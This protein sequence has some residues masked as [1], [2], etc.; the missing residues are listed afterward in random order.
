MTILYSPSHILYSWFQKNAQM[1]EKLQERPYCIDSIDIKFKIRRFRMEKSAGL[2]T[3]KS[4]YSSFD[5]GSSTAFK[6]KSLYLHAAFPK[7]NLY[8]RNVLLV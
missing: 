5:H 1:N 8:C 3:D 2:C 6:L 7:I 4:I